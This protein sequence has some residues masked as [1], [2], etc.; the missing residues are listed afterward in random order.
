MRNTSRQISVILTMVLLVAGAAFAQR[1]VGVPPSKP[2]EQNKS[3]HELV[4]TMHEIGAINRDPKVG[5]T[6]S[7]AKRVLLVINPLRKKPKLTETQAQQ[8]LK[9][10]KPI[11]TASQTKALRNIKPDNRTYRPNAPGPQHKPNSADGKYRPGAQSNH[12]PPAKPLYSADFNPFYEK[13]TKD[14]SFNSYQAKR[15]SEIIGEI[16]RTS[17]G[18]KLKP[19]PKPGYTPN[20]AAP[21]DKYV[22]G[23]AAPKKS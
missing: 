9:K 17:K 7:Q 3:T 22:P 18:L 23:K 8:A 6:Q 10:L 1:P 2:K 20:K 5:L 21:K 14:I 16:E 12:R 11:L 19:T 13:I 4:R 15:M